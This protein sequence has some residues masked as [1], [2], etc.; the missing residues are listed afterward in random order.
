MFERNFKNAVVA[1]GVLLTTSLVQGQ[2]RDRIDPALALARICVSEAGWTCFETGDGMGIHEVILRGAERHGLSYSSYARS[3]SSAAGREREH[4]TDRAR[5]V[6]ELNERGTA[7]ESWPRH[8]YARTQD[9]TTRLRP[10]PSW[11]RYR[12]RW[13]AVLARAREVVRAYNLSNIESWGVCQSAVHDWGGSMD[14]ERA[15]RLRLIEVECGDTRN[16]F[17]ARPSLVANEVGEEPQ[18]TTGG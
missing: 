9:G 15:E 5:W 18:E 13:L 6:R 14:R 1:V 17:Y 3:Y 4:M 2:S 16:D 12:E 8:T 7:P 11:G 10:A